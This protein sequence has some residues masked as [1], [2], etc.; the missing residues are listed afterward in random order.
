MGNKHQNTDYFPAAAGP[1]NVTPS[2]W[3]VNG[4]STVVLFG[5]VR[6]T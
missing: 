4:N 3:R 5:Y 6:K 1:I 2:D